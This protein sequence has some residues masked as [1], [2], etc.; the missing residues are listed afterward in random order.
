MLRLSVFAIVFAVT[1]HVFADDVSNDSPES[2]L[3]FFEPGMRVGVAVVEGT[4]MVRLLTYTEEDFQAALELVDVRGSLRRASILAESNAIVR[5]R[6][7]KYAARNKL[8][9]ESKSNVMITI[10][11]RTSMGTVRIIGED[12]ML[13]E[14][15]DDRKSRRVIPKTSIGMI[16]I[17]A[18]PFSFLETNRRRN[19]DESR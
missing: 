11:L 13:V 3:G 5:D 19:S 4:A 1:S 14:I 2:I 17:D 7:E 12:Y 16:Y 10:P 15:E 18:T 9:D 8:S 6:F